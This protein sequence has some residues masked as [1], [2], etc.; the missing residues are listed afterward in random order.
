MGLERRK[1]KWFGKYWLRLERRKYKISA[2]WEREISRRTGTYSKF[3]YHELQIKIVRYTYKRGGIST[4]DPPGWANTR[5]QQ[6][7]LYCTNILTWESGTRGPDSF[8]KVKY[9][10]RVGYKDI[11]TWGEGGPEN[12]IPL[13]GLNIHTGLAI[14]LLLPRE[15]GTREPD[16]FGRVKYP[17][18]VGYKCSGSWKPD[19]RCRLS[20]AHV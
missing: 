4:S 17:H 2:H 14:K 12:Q 5:I 11:L 10:H 9:P 3:L 1:R 20:K 18:R 16:S 6:G 7:G 13:A 19:S 15:R 8:G